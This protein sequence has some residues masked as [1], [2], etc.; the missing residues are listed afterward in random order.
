LIDSFAKLLAKTSDADAVGMIGSQCPH[1]SRTPRELSDPK[2]LPPQLSF[3]ALKKELQHLLTSSRYICRKQRDDLISWI[4]YGCQ[5]EKISEEDAKLWISRLSQNAIDYIPVAGREVILKLVL[6]IIEAAEEVN[7]NQSFVLYD[8]GTIHPDIRSACYDAGAVQLNLID[9][10]KRLEIIVLETKEKEFREKFGAFLENNPKYSEELFSISTQNYEVK[11]TDERCCFLGAVTDEVHQMFKIDWDQD[12]NGSGT[13]GGAITECVYPGY[14]HAGDPENPIFSRGWSVTSGHV[15][16]KTISPAKLVDAQKEPFVSAEDQGEDIVLDPSIDIGLFELTGEQT[17]YVDEE[18]LGASRLAF[19][20]S[21]KWMEFRTKWKNDYSSVYAHFIAQVDMVRNV[22][23]NEQEFVDIVG[24]VK[25]AVTELPEGVDKDFA[26][27][28]CTCLDRLKRQNSVSFPNMSRPIS[29]FKL[30]PPEGVDRDS[31]VFKLGKYGYKTG[32]I[33]EGV[34][35]T[36]TYKDFLEVHRKDFIIAGDS[37][38]LALVEQGDC[39]YPIGWCT[40]TID[41]DVQDLLFEGGA[42]VKTGTSGFTVTPPFRLHSSGYK[43]D[44]YSGVVVAEFGTHAFF[45]FGD[46][47]DFDSLSEMFRIKGP[48]TITPKVGTR[49]TKFEV[50][51]GVILKFETCLKAIVRKKGLC[52]HCIRFLGQKMAFCGRG[53]RSKQPLSFPSRCSLKKKRMQ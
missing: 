38:S 52:V 39:V 42:E 49:V 11:T 18:G 20:F 4:R 32:C 16:N 51:V 13:I 8:G 36:K 31:I 2:G 41:F 40:G 29:N 26:E 22:L 25:A 44:E 17:Q 3:V 47:K 9:S 14:P 28:V 15:V 1:L 7:Q 34:F 6:P 24:A 27:T 45:A 12:V 19:I 30:A 35:E 50:K 23:E 10:G 21:S 37:G 43:R 53:K 48:I 33:R 46:L 5:V